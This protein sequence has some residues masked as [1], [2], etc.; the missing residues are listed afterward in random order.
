MHDRRGDNPSTSAFRTDSSLA[1]AWYAKADKLK[2]LDLRSIRTHKWHI[3]PCSAMTGANLNE[4][5]AWVVEDAKSRL[6]LY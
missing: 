1:C 2:N 6:F 3:L 4:G 5:L